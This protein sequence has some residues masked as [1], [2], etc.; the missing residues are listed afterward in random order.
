MKSPL[1]GIAASM[2]SAALLSAMLPMPATAQQGATTAQA[3]LAT[4][5]DR[6]SYM[7]GMDIGARL[8]FHAGVR[9]RRCAGPDRNSTWPRSSVRSATRWPAASRCSTKPP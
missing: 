9:V 6:V 3:A 4:D 5:R 2:L 7:V 8:G 1:R